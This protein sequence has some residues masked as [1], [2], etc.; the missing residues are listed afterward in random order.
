[1]AEGVR[2]D[3]VGGGYV[4]E[5]ENDSGA[6]QLTRWPAVVQGGD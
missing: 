2:E 6:A 5:K 4:N 1:M 3:S